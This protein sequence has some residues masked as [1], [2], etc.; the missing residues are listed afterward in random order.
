MRTGTV[1][2]SCAPK[3]RVRYTMLKQ[4]HDVFD[5]LANSIS[6][7]IATTSESLAVDNLLTCSL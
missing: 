4:R 3:K 1:S 2:T 5:W 6:Q 7:R